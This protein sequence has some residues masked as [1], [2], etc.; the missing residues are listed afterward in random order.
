MEA[1]KPLLTRETFPVGPLQ[2]NRMLN[3]ALVNSHHV[4]ALSGVPEGI[5]AGGIRRFRR[6]GLLFAERNVAW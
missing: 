5:V 4:L 1:A 3:G 2:C 6:R